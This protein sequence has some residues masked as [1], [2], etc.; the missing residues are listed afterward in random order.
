METPGCL[1]C[2]M[3]CVFYRISVKSLRNRSW[4][5]NKPLIAEFKLCKLFISFWIFQI[6]GLP[7]F[8]VSKIPNIEQAR[9]PNII[10]LL[11]V[12][13]SFLFVEDIFNIV[14]NTSYLHSPELTIGQ[15][16]RS[17]HGYMLVKGTSQ[18]PR[19]VLITFVLAICFSSVFRFAMYDLNRFSV[20]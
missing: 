17:Q 11:Q 16:L 15:P 4:N 10:F 9:K 20:G 5:M 7:L 14:S 12:C 6:S 3:V 13:W 19:C 2:C 8:G 1:F 18:Y